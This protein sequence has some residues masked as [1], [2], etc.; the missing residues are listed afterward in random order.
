MT[1]GVQGTADMAALGTF[2]VPHISD[3]ELPGLAPCAQTIVATSTAYSA[4]MVGSAA[5]GADCR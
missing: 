5:S 1:L 4:A 3:V 2:I